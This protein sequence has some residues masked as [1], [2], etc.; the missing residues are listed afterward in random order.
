MEREGMGFVGERCWLQPCRIEGR[1]GLRSYC[2]R[3]RLRSVPSRETTSTQTHR[4][5]P[6][7]TFT[8]PEGLPEMMNSPF[9]M[10]RSR[11]HCYT[12]GLHLLAHPIPAPCWGTRQKEH[13]VL[14]LMMWICRAY[15]C[16]DCTR[17]DREVSSHF[18]YLENRSRGFDVTWQPVRGNVTA[19]P[20]TITFPWG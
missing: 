8:A 16:A 7:V 17:A 13:T 12:E 11:V 18:E 14:N 1:V 10:S 15:C 19:H 6:V 3:G 5:I 9:V 20:R 2:W 4:P